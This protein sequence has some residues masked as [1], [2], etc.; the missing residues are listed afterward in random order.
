MHLLETS[1]ISGKKVDIN[2]D[3]H[4]L[5]NITCI[6]LKHTEQQLLCK[7]DHFEGNLIQMSEDKKSCK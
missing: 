3:I 5:M 6:I 1:I 7:S 4:A 2:L